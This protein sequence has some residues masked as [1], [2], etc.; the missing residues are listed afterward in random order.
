MESDQVTSA[1]NRHATGHMSTNSKRTIDSA[2]YT[3]PQHQHTIVD[4]IY[5]H[6]SSSACSIK[7]MDFR[8][9]T[10]KGIAVDQVSV[11][12]QATWS[13]DVYYFSGI[14]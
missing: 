8:M 6:V 5:T 11:V 14:M 4:H 12:D 13:A 7:W 1:E 10:K 3:M 2:K 9:Q